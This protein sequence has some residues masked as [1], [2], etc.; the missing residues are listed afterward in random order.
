MDNPVFTAAVGALRQ[1]LGSQ[2]V[3]TDDASRELY[4]TDVFRYEYRPVAVIQPATKT[5]LA[6]AVGIATRAGLSV[7]PRGGGMSYTDA[8]LPDRAE[9]IIVDTRRLNRIVEINTT[10]MYV[11]LEAGVTWTQLN[12]ALAEKGVRPPFWGTGSGLYATVGAGLSQNALNYGSCKYGVASDSV[13]GLEVVLADGSLLKTGSGATTVNPSPF[14]RNY[15]PDLT[16]AFLGDNGALG[17]KAQATLRLLERPKA[18]DFLSF[19]F[20]SQHDMAAAMTTVSR[21]GI[22]SECTGYDPRFLKQRLKRTSIANDLQLLKGVATSGGTVMQG[23][24]NAARVAVAGRRFLEGAAYTMHA[25]VEGRSDAEVKLGVEAI[26]AIAKDGQEIEASV[27]RISR[28]RPFPPPTLLLTNKGEIWVPVHCIVP[29]SRLN[30]MLDAI[31][32]YFADHAKIVEEFNIDWGNTMATCGP[33]ATLIEPS[34]FYA[35]ARNPFVDYICGPEVLKNVPRLPAN[36]KTREA[37]GKIRHDLADLF[38][39]MGA[40]HLQIGRFYRYRQSREPATFA[41]LKAIKDYL[42]PRNLM[43][44]GALGL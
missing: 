11:T 36:P 26:R 43:N 4:S 18:I 29:N 5:E 22:A 6:E 21:S 35:D 24:K 19:E 32:G 31:N 34:F 25:T 1:C 41:F 15:G 44:P 23:L 20:G 10:D 27:P 7:V 8:Y 40:T 3:L 2:H 17:I 9:S 37:V 33:Q 14:F 28:G 16:G 39:E 30:A 13:L 42:D 38:V 12:D